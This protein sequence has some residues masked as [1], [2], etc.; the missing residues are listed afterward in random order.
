MKKVTLIGLEF[1]GSHDAMLDQNFELFATERVGLDDDGFG[2]VYISATSEREIDESL[3]KVTHKGALSAIS[4]KNV[5][6]RTDEEIAELTAHL[7]GIDKAYQADN[8]CVGLEL[9]DGDVVNK[10]YFEWGLQVKIDPKQGGYVMVEM[11]G[12]D[13]SQE[14]AMVTWTERFDDGSF[15]L[16]D[17]KNNEV[18]Y[19]PDTQTLVEFNYENQE[20]KREMWRDLN[21]KFLNESDDEERARLYDLLNRL[22]EV[23]PTTEC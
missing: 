16:K 9:G 7:E 13:A 23:I 1:F 12:D 10:S 19:S 11:V 15:F 2:I 8:D 3:L 5:V 18:V 6:E 4:K 22:D 20:R 17:S 21:N 14:F